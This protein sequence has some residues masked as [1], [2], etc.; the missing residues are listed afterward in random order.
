[1]NQEQLMG[2]YFRLQQELS[3]AYSAQP[4]NSRRIDRLANELAGTEREITAAG[5]IYER[6]SESTYRVVQTGHVGRADSAGFERP[7]GTIYGTSRT[8]PVQ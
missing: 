5:L 1:M 6:Q 3:I 2:R 7:A 8:R 4:W